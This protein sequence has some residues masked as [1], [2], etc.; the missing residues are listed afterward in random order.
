MKDAAKKREAQWQDKQNG[1]E[2]KQKTPKD[3]HGIDRKVTTK[4][5]K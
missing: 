5:R 3:Q 2:P 4:P 1:I